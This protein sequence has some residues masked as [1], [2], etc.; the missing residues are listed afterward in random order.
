[1][2][3]VRVNTLQSLHQLTPNWLLTG[4]RLVLIALIAKPALSKF[5]TYS[6]SVAFFDA[7]GI[8]FP[9]VMVI[10]AGIIELAAVVMLLFGIG[11]RLA[12]LALIPVMIVAI[13]YVALDWKNIVVLVGSSVILVLGTGSYSLW[14]PTDRLLG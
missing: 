3:E 6:D 4:L 9:A 8:P 7:Y 1:M 13:L 2:G 11:G 5:V 10:V 14:Q 12:A